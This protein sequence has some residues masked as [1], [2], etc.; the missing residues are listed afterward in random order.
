MTSPPNRAAEPA[1]KTFAPLAALVGVG[2]PPDPDPGPEPEPE[3][4]PPTV[5]VA[6]TLTVGGKIPVALVVGKVAREVVRLEDPRTAEVTGPP[7]VR[8]LAV[9][10]L[11]LPPPPPPLR[12]I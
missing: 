6:V 11:L 4:P 12:T 5:F 7:V 9:V 10:E 1:A 3:P 8:E 2:K